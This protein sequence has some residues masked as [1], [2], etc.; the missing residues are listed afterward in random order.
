M[1]V[2]LGSKNVGVGIVTKLG[3]DIINEDITIKENGVYSA[4]EGY[5][6]LGTVTVD[7]EGGVKKYLVNN[8]GEDYQ[9]GDKVLVDF[10]SNVTKDNEF[11]IEQTTTGRSY[12]RPVWLDNDRFMI[13]TNDATTS[14]KYI[15]E[16]DT[17]NRYNINTLSAAQNYFNYIPEMGMFYSGGGDYIYVT[18]TVDENCTITQATENDGIIGTFNGNVW[19]WRNVNSSKGGVYCNDKNLTGAWGIYVYCV[20]YDTRRYL[21]RC[22]YGSYK[23]MILCQINDD[24]ASQRQTIASSAILPDN[25]KCVG[26]TGLNVGDYVIMQPN[27]ANNCAAISGTT[28]LGSTNYNYSAYRIGEKQPIVELAS[29]D[30][31]KQFL[32][33]KY[34]IWNMDQRNNCLIIGTR[35]NVYILEFDKETKQFREVASNFELPENPNGE[36]I[37]NASLSPDKKKLVVYVG[38]IYSGSQ[39]LCIYD[40]NSEYS[41]TIVKNTSINYNTTTS[42]T[43][44]ATGNVDDEGKIEVS[45]N[46]TI[47]QDITI[48][49]NGEYEPDDNHTGFGKVIVNVES[50]GGGTKK[51]VTNSTTNTYTGGEKVLVNL[52]IRPSELSKGY[53]ISST[54]DEFGSGFVDNNTVF[55]LSEAKRFKYTFSN[56]SWSDLDVTQWAGNFQNP[57]FKF[58]NDISV[59]GAASYT[60]PMHC[61]RI[62]SSELT[63]LKTYYQ[64]LGKVL[65]KDYYYK[66]SDNTVGRF[67]RTTNTYG[68]SLKT[69]TSTSSKLKYGYLND[70]GKGLLVDTAGSLFFITIDEA[71]TDSVVTINSTLTNLNLPSEIIVAGCTGANVGDFI[72]FGTNARY[73]YDI[74]S[75]STA[76]KKISNILPYE[77]IQ[78]GEDGRTLKPRPDLFKKFQTDNCLVQYDNRNDVLTIG[79]LDNVYVYKFNRDV[80][81]FEQL[82]YTF[83]LPDNINK[84]FCYRLAFSPDMSKAIVSL[85]TSLTSTQI[86]LFT[87]GNANWEIVDNQIINYN[88]TTSFSAITTGEVDEDGKVEV[89]LTLPDEVDLVINTNVEINEGDIVIVGVE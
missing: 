22:I 72:F 55:Y 48:N 32:D 69:I 46:G 17:W 84:D 81:K 36:F 63:L 29:D 53:D 86:V 52:G 3:S 14:F 77:I 68:S 4:N 49:E 21:L 9:K 79:T 70:N 42:Y 37:Y 64:Y 39:N 20:D 66:S 1:P 34:T 23:N 73:T 12:V 51:F 58:S 35:D 80:K 61:F 8:S 88:A 56:N 11:N 74:N 28:S 78:S 83:I 62:S 40:V 85:K 60:Q 13:P 43:G 27:I 15:L 26:C 47:N 45:I 6:G 65:D 59:F 24:G 31:L 5:T 44:T 38:D 25:T 16:G 10:R 87:L 57:G 67:Y 50:S 76:P 89:K 7:V 75:N 41:W 54:G 18:K 2:Y 19:S 30:V 71:N 33:K 82:N